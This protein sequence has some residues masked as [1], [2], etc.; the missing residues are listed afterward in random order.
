M[1]KQ[2]FLDQI[3][4]IGTCADDAQR[5]NLL[6]SLAD[7]VSTTFDEHA[8]LTEQNTK[9]KTDMESLRSANMQLFLQVGESRK[10]QPPIDDGGNEPP[11]NTLTYENLF[12]EKGELK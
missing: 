6:T 11:S 12:N 9:Y 7:T 2:E 10:Q 8:T 4:A 1:T 3:T 5:R